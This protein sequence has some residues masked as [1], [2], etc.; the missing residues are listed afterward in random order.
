[1]SVEVVRTGIRRQLRAFEVAFVRLR[2]SL[3]AAEAAVVFE[4]VLA[5]CLLEGDRPDFGAM[6]T[7]AGP[8]TMV[9]EIDRPEVWGWLDQVAAGLSAVGVA[10]SLAAATSAKQPEVF[11]EDRVP[12]AGVQFASLELPWQGEYQWPLSAA[13]TTTLVDHAA[14]WC[15][16][17][18]QQWLGLDWKFWVPGPDTRQLA[19]PMAAAASSVQTDIVS[20]NR[21][22]A[23]RVA[24]SWLAWGVQVVRSDLGWREQVALCRQALLWQP[25]LVSWAV[26]GTADYPSLSHT[27]N[28]C[29]RPP[30]NSLRMAESGLRGTLVDAVQGI[31]LLTGTHLARA[32]DLSGWQV[33]QVSSD[34]YLVEARDLA[35]WFTGTAIDPD[36]YAQAAHDFGAMLVTPQTADEFGLA[37]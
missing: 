1:M 11:A 34:R 2:S 27:L 18:G 4:A 21:L 13:E 6:L 23:R 15:D 35:P 32:H 17:G 31:Q 30:V 29:P 20:V 9:E 14:Q 36:V 5:G 10:G 26:V 19:A 8:V 16:L 7:A 33:T 24:A 22:E 3:D 28:K 37:N 25:E 12:T